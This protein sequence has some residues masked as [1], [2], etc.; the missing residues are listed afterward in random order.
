[1]KDPIILLDLKDNVVVCRRA[2][3]AG[4]RIEVAEREVVVAC[5]VQLG[6]KIACASIDPGASVVKYGITIG[7]A[8]IAIAPG[9][10]V[11]LHNMR[12]NYISTHTRAQTGKE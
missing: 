7:S 5:D 1:M 11:H 10:W 6:H 9:D 3:A 12:S 2:V 8:T 4:E